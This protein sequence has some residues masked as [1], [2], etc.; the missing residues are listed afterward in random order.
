MIRK[1]LISLTLLFVI[2]SATIAQESLTLTLATFNKWSKVVSNTGFPLTESFNDGKVEYRAKFML[3]MEKAFISRVQGK[4]Y[5]LN[6]ESIYC[7]CY[8]FKQL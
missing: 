6:G 3:S 5:A 1:L 8:P 7:T 4:I 2:S